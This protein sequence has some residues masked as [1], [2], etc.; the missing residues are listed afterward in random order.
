MA[1]KRKDDPT[2]RLTAKQLAFI[3]AYS[4]SLNGAEA[5]RTAYPTSKSWRPERVQVEASKLLKHPIIA[6]RVAERAKKAAAIAEEKFEINAERVLQELAAIAFQNSAD[7]FEWGAFERPVFRKDKATGKYEKVVD[8]NGEEVTELVPFA[9]AKP[10]AE[11]S[12]QQKSAIISASE[13]TS[14]TGDKLVEIKMAD[15]VGALKLLGQHLSLFKVGIDANVSGKNGG[16]IQLV[17]S[18]AEANL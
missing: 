8:E 18:T 2:K 7:V 12:R 13:T 15:K 16:P 4:L 9:R 3:E 10:S 6:Q 14:R 1:N 17:I 11:L 5:Y